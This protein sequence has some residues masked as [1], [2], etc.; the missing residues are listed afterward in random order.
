MYIPDIHRKQAMIYKN[1]KWML[2]DRLK[3]NKILLLDNYNN[4]YSNS[5]KMRVNKN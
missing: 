3:D 4:Y 5:A 1:D 2:E